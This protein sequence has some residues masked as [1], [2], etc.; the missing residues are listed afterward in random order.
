M[1]AMAENIN[2]QKEIESE[3]G[4]LQRRLLQGREQE[5]LG[6]A[7]ELHDGPL[8]DLMD[9]TYQIHEI[10]ELESGSNTR[11]KLNELQVTVNQLSRSIRMICGELRPPTLAPFGLG[12][13]ITSHA[14]QFEESHPEIKIKLN[15]MDDGQALSEPV[16]IVLFRIYQAALN[17]ILRHAQASRVSI[18]F[19]LNEKQA[20]LRIQDNGQGFILPAHWITLARQGHLGIVGARERAN[21]VGGI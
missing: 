13:T 15:L 14:I 1:I 11:E 8:Q 20:I 21:E 18:Q 19:K 3:L 9:V 12:K 6:I 16:R 17:N 10:A 4:E 7:Q 2:A 5:R